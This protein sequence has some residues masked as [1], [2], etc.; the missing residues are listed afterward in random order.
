MKIQ[1]DGKKR[2]TAKR[3]RQQGLTYAAIGGLLGL[4]RQRVHQL[5]MGALPR[6]THCKQCDS[7][8]PPTCTV[9]CKFECQQIWHGNNRRK[10]GQGYAPNPKGRECV[11]CRKPIESPRG[12]Q[13]THAG[14]CRKANDA[15]LNKRACERYNAK[16]K[17]E[18]AKR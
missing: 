12:P 16:R 14:E 13:K 4:S 1:P 17:Q 2:L 15:A 7:R 8:L 18:V 11:V 6:A 3:L 5:L 10:S 9:F